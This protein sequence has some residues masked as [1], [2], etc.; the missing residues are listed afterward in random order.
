[1]T[2]RLDSLGYVRRLEEVGVE[3][4]VAEA[5]VEVVQDFPLEEVATKADL[6][7]LEDRLSARM[8]ALE[9]R[10]DGKLDVLEQRMTMKLGGMLIA[11]VGLAL[12]GVRP[13]F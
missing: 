12:A 1:M 8:D 11:A 10:F 3:R 5:H 4:R 13:L 6:G 7:R 2:A 9:Q